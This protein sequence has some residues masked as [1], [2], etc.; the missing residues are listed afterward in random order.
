M[1]LAYEGA[2]AHLAAQR[3]LVLSNGQMVRCD[4]SGDGDQVRLSEGHEEAEAGVVVVVGAVVAGKFARATS[5]QLT[6]LLEHLRANA[7]YLGI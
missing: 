3:R 5:K 1:G 6:C 2:R 7:I 4:S